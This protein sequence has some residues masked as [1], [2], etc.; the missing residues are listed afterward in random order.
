MIALTRALT[1]LATGVFLN[2]ANYLLLIGDRCRAYAHGA[3]HRSMISLVD[4][5]VVSGTSFLTTIILGRTCLPA[6]LGLYAIGFNVSVVLLGIPKAL[7]WTPYTTFCPGMPEDDRRWY[8]GSTLAHQAILSTAVGIAI[9]CVGGLLSL[10]GGAGGLGSVL[11][12]LGPAIGLMLLREHVRR[13]CFSRLQ[14]GEALAVDI[15]VAALQISGM[16]ALANAGMLTA[17]RAYLVIAASCLPVVVV[18]VVVS[19]GGLALRHD[20]MLADLAKNWK[21]ARWLFSGAL[22][23]AASDALYPWVLS[24]LRGTTAVGMLSAANGAIFLTNPLILGLSNFFG[25]HAAHCYAG[26]GLPALQRLVTKASILVALVMSSVTLVLVLCGGKLVALLFGAEY[27]GQG[28]VVT[29]LAL[30]Q[31][32]DVVAIPIMLGLLG[33]GRGDLLLKSYGV[34][35]ALTSTVG[36]WCVYQ[37]GEIGVGYGQAISN[38]GSG[39]VQWSAFQCLVSTWEAET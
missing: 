15:V 1:S 37:F 20:R 31:L 30:G 35:L 34:R 6:E 8:T 27:A 11:V 16:L 28:S 19:R 29:A 33:A 10:Q 38:L 3:A 23:Y 32:A 18:W 39:L 36:M 26:A 4:Q 24:G 7:I 17:A 14:V 25:P 9:S 22:L 13:V 21:F 12:I 5:A 2:L